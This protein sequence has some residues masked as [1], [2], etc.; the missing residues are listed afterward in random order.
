MLK[1]NTIKAYGAERGAR[2][3]VV[4]IVCTSLPPGL[5]LEPVGKGTAERCLV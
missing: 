4:L 3:E 1:V 2:F 5:W